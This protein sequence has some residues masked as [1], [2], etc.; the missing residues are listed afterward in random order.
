MTPE[1]P[2]PTRPPLVLRFLRLFSSTPGLVLIAVA[3]NLFANELDRLV[4]EVPSS[5]GHVHALTDLIGPGGL[6]QVGNWIAWGSSTTSPAAFILASTLAD[7]AFIACYGLL[8]LRLIRLCFDH[9]ITTDDGYDGARPIVAYIALG[10]L[11][12]ADFGEDVLILIS[13]GPL[14]DP[15]ASEIFHESGW[16][17]LSYWLSAFTI[18]KWIAL[19]FFLLYVV[20]SDR[21]GAKIRSFLPDALRALYAQRLVAIVVVAVGALCLLPL[22]DLFEQ[23]SDVYRGLFTFPNAALGIDFRALSTLVA[24]IV[25]GL[26]LFAISRERARHYY[27]L[28]LGQARHVAWLRGWLYCALVIGA[29]ALIIG[30]WKSWQSTDPLPL[31]VVLGVLVVVAI[32]SVLIRIFG[33]GGVPAL[34]RTNYV[35][36]AP[37]V[38]VAGDL[39]VATWV[40]IAFFAPF[41]AIV[42]PLFLTGAPDLFASTYRAALPVLIAVEILLFGCGVCFAVLIW[43]R[44]RTDSVPAESAPSAPVEQTGS[45]APNAVLHGLRAAPVR[46]IEF[47]KSVGRPDVDVEIRARNR[48]EAAQRK[49][50]WGML[51]IASVVILGLLFFPT[52]GGWLLGPVG[53]LILIIGSWADIIGTLIAVLGLRTPPEIFSALRLRSTPVVTLLVVVPLV[54]AFVGGPPQLHAVRFLP[55]KVSASTPSRLDLL[56]A[57][58]KWNAAQRKCSTT[59]QV[60]SGHKVSV[61][62]LVLVA[63][64]GGGIRAATWTVDVLTK[65]ASA[66]ACSD[67]STFLSSGASGGSIGL[68]TFHVSGRNYKAQSEVSTADFAGPVALGTDVVALLTGDEVGAV[69]GIRVPTQTNPV[70][71]GSPWIWHD[72][73]ALQELTWSSEATQ[74][75][76]RIDLTDVQPT[77]YLVLNSTDSVSGCKVIVSQLDLGSF[78]TSTSPD[79]NG[80]SVGLSNTIDLRDSLGACFYQLQWS[81]AAELS[82]R[83][84]VVSPPGRIDSRTLPSTCKEPTVKQSDA[85][86]KN[87]PQRAPMQ[88]VDGG[89]TDNSAIGTISDIAAPLS[90]IIARHNATVNGSKTQPFVVPVVLYASNDPGLDLTA[91]A[92]RTKPDALVP[93]SVLGA[94]HAAEISPATW[95]TR[96]VTG[97][98]GVCDAYDAEHSKTKKAPAKPQ[99]RL[100]DEGL[101]YFHNWIP[102]GA[103]VVSPS[104][105]PA[106]SVPLGWTLSD[107]SSAR[108]GNEASSQAAC[109]SV[110]QAQANAPTVPT[111]SR[112][113]CRSDSGYGTFGR[114]LSFYSVGIDKTKLDSTPPTTK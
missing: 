30:L 106:V 113:T 71:S 22:P 83:F 33:R 68:T 75:A 108:L 46:G 73:T 87:V 96:A 72:R 86:K 48:D 15:N 23:A 10:L 93:L 105:A 2:A 20:L 56:R 100:C 4:D 24:D 51:A 67:D 79:C 90:A 28:G 39:L 1:Q 64:Q 35:A 81:T 40:A 53:A 88:L 13:D 112:T 14:F 17:A 8:A 107:F 65:L 54:V 102:G 94:A 27:L 58:D 12:F 36:L 44:L 26:M 52:Y 91:T 31:F 34:V 109:G 61:R 38:G 60:A 111:T 18:A 45:R 50:R 11:V 85:S 98:S 69:T 99:L 62:P 104:T 78:S 5:H 101:N 59:F 76:K 57:F 3:S 77:G 55:A 110:T 9:W 42:T 6:T 70:N 19:G 25:V 47:L 29:F 43:R 92:N 7:L 89:T 32:A 66:G 16:V 84:P 21:V 49:F 103:T 41:K 97:Y 114:L 74:F 95:L 82:A 37:R 63:A 80:P